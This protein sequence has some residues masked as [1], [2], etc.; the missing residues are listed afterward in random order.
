MPLAVSLPALRAFAE[1]GRQGSIKRAAAA[2]GVTPGAVSQQVK[3]L[4]R[5]LGVLLLNRGN[6]EI[7]LTEDGQS[8]VDRLA[9]AFEQIN[10]AV[11]HLERRRPRRE[12]LTVSTTPSFAAAWLVPRLGSFS[13]QHPD[14]EIRVESGVR[15]VDLLCEPVDIALRHGTGNYPG[16]DAVKLVTPRLM[17]VGSPKLL[18]AGRPIRVAEDCLAYPLLHDR[19]RAAWALWMKVEGLNG[20]RE[21]TVRGPSFENDLLLIQAAIS[22]QGLAIVRDIYA[23]DELETGRI[24]I[25][26]NSQVPTEEAYFFV[27]RTSFKRVEK[28]QTFYDWLRHQLSSEALLS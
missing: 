28:A 12:T 15:L 23:R 26:F 6:R 1:V 20:T 13:Q 21:E 7:W 27:T 9:I 16:L 19:N 2:L 11:L 22:G 24:V 8:L 5:R 25:A 4:E 10:D 14:I 3:V 17:I 18:E